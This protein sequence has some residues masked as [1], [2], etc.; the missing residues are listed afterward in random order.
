MT[1]ITWRTYNT[2]EH[3]RMMAQKLANL[4]LQPVSILKSE[5]T[6]DAY[7][8]YWLDWTPSSGSLVETCQPSEEATP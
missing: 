2:I 8:Y 3:A 4:H 1:A 7:T 5:N 6:N